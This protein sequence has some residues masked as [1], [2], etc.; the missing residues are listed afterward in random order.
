MLGQVRNCFRIKCVLDS[1]N[2]KNQS[3]VKESNRYIVIEC[4][5]IPISQKGYIRFKQ[6]FVTYLKRSERVRSDHYSI[7]IFQEDNL[8]F[9]FIFITFIYTLNLHII[10]YAIIIVMISQCEAVRVFK[11]R[12]TIGRRF[13]LFFILFEIF[14]SFFFLIHSH[15]GVQFLLAFGLCSLILYFISFNFV[16]NPAYPVK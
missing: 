2:V 8:V 9:Y 10:F 11:L 4:I 7:S 6:R 13:F 3:Y 5:I 15:A 14:P 16:H 12:Q 1:Y